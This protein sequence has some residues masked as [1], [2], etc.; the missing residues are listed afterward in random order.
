MQVKTTLESR[1]NN[2]YILDHD[3]APAS[4]L[5]NLPLILKTIDAAAEYISDY[6]S[7]N[8]ST[9]HLGITWHQNPPGQGGGAASIGGMY[10]DI[11]LDQNYAYE[12]FNFS[13]AETGKYE[14]GIMIFL[15]DKG[16]LTLGSDIFYL[17]QNPGPENVI[18][19]DQP[20]FFSAVVHELLHSMG[21]VWMEGYGDNEL[22]T[23]I[24]DGTRY[25]VS[26]AVLSVLPSGL[27]LSS[28]D[29]GS[30]YVTGLD[31]P[32]DEMLFGGLMYDGRT[33]PVDIG[34]YIHD[35]G[36]QQ[37]IGKIDLAILKDL[38]YEVFNDPN[39]PVYGSYSEVEEAKL[40]EKVNEY[41]GYDTLPGPEPTSKPV[42]TPTPEPNDPLDGDDIIY[43]VRGK[44]KL[45]GGT[46]ADEF[47][48]DSFDKFSKKGADKI[49]DFNSA[50]GDFLG[51]YNYE[52]PRVMSGRQFK[53]AKVNKKRDLKALSKQDYDFI[54]FEKKGRLFHD[55]NGYEKGW[56]SVDEGG[57]VAIL[58]G[59]P[60]LNIND[61]IVW[62]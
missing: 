36:A 26:P 23:V 48:F 49:I 40:I 2:K 58:K 24:R 38:G 33:E 6:V 47:A 32:Y 34:H 46:G 56:G 13:G 8:D 16:D 17:D 44:G 20:S 5:D 51:F 7:F 25:L 3:P 57:L 4:Q 42:R 22:P 12:G 59:K 61:I 55:A 37:S 41:L 19:V 14:G 62:S 10:Q 21:L 11:I 28:H 9:I 31:S 1:F 54:Y 30:H 29:G 27:P 39:L 52:I 18:P 50:E 43:S 15:D 53:Y 60:E 45:K 35:I